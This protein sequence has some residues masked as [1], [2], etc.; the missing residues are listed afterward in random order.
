[1]CNFHEQYGHLA[2]AVRVILYERVF[3]P[4]AALLEIVCPHIIDGQTFDFYDTRDGQD[5][6]LK[7]L[8]GRYTTNHSLLLDKFVVIDL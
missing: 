8:E 3:L 1:M 6:P 7:S 2:I 4:R 5:L